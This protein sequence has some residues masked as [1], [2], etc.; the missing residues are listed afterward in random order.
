MIG[1]LLGTPPGHHFA[2]QFAGARTKVDDI[3][4]LPDGGLVVLDD[5][6][7]VAFVAQVAQGIQQHAVVPRVQAD[8]RLVQHI[9]D[10]AEIRS[11]L[12]GQPNALRLA[13]AQ[14]GSAPVQRQVSQAHIP[15]ETQPGKN[16]RNDVTGDSALACR[17][18]QGLKTFPCLVDRQRG[19]RVDPLPRKAHGQGFGPQPPPSAD[20][21]RRRIARSRR[22]PFFFLAGLFRVKPLDPFPGAE[23]PWTPAMPTIEREQAGIQLGKTMTTGRTRASRRIQPLTASGRHTTQGPL[24]ILQGPAHRLQQHLSL[25]L[26][27]MHD[28]HGHIDIVFAKAIETRPGIGGHIPT[29]D[30]KP[31][32]ALFAGPFGKI[33]VEALAGHHQGSQ[34]GRFPPAAIPP[35]AFGDR[36]GALHF[37]GHPAIMAILLPELDEQKP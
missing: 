7:G 34:Q 37:D 29:I 14:G 26:A 3:V 32:E 15:Q 30:P 18:L 35:D 20:R 11:Q 4:R 23:T 1:K 36:F 19:E 27:G 6:D 33:G 24:A 8:R 9:T 2:T 16:L 13:A 28:R 10:A 12:R 21:A 25:I 31:I 17:Q 22:Q 5:H